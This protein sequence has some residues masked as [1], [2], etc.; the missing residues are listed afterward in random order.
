MSQVQVRFSGSQDSRPVNYGNKSIS[1]DYFQ[2]GVLSVAEDHYPAAGDEHERDGVLN[3]G[4]FCGIGSSGKSVGFSFPPAI[5]NWDSDEVVGENMSELGTTSGGL[6]LESSTSNSLSQ[7]SQVPQ[8][9]RSSC[10]RSNAVRIREAFSFTDGTE[11]ENV[12]D[13]NSKKGC[14]FIEF[15]VV[16]AFKKRTTNP[17][18]HQSC[19]RLQIWLHDQLVFD[20]ED[21]V[22]QGERRLHVV[23]SVG[24]PT[25]HFYVPRLRDTSNLRKATRYFLHSCY[26]SPKVAS[27]HHKP[28]V[29]DNRKEGVTDMSV[30]TPNSLVLEVSRLAMLH[31]D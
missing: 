13:G 21:C 23:A 11:P 30:P 10:L 2:L 3:S 8:Q 20:V 26:L 29:E 25:V 27:V 16:Y 17:E 6:S 18:D 28:E 4:I 14:Q 19:L 12:V 5:R 31:W 7:K 15:V 9:I 1:S 24:S 22:P